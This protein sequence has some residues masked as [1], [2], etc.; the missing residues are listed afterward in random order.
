M[1]ATCLSAPTRRPTLQHGLRKE[2]STASTALDKLNSHIATTPLAAVC[3]ETSTRSHWLQIRKCLCAIVRV[4]NL[5]EGHR[6]L[7]GSAAPFSA[8]IWSAA[9]RSTPQANPEEA[10]PSPEMTSGM[11]WNAQQWRGQHQIEAPVC[12]QSLRTRWPHPW[13]RM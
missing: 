4:Q 8:S 13:K 2:L 3:V 11:Q 1:C 10:R 9:L 6:L 12:T 7:H 5:Q